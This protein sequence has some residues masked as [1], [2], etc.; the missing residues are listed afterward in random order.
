MPANAYP[1]LVFATDATTLPRAELEPLVA[2]VF[3]DAEPAPSVEQGPLQAIVRL[4]DY[5][6]TL[7]YDDDSE[8]LPGR[9]G[10]FAPTL[11]RR[12]ISKCTTMIDFS[13]DA[14]P[15]GAHGDDAPG[16]AG[17]LTK[18]A[19]DRVVTAALDE[20]APWGDLTSTAL[21]PETS[22]ATAE[23]VAREPGVFSGGLAA[24]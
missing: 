14:D 21:I 20:D 4:G 23:L 12:R 19:I 10:D 22:T 18:T 7:W 6:F 1:H 9:Y 8:G 3:A 15:D 17:M 24:T 16:G 5:A 11:K 2:Q 13:G